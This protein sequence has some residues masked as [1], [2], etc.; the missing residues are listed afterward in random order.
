LFV[1]LQFQGI[2]SKIDIVIYVYYYLT[3]KEGINYKITLF[4]VRHN[5]LLYLHLEL[6]KIYERNISQFYFDRLMENTFFSNNAVI[7]NLIFGN[8]FNIIKYRIFKLLTNIQIS[9]FQV[10]TLFFNCE[11]FS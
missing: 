5:F 3:L 7:Q 10:R 11:L 1:L 8:F 6:S 9:V 4:M 2:H